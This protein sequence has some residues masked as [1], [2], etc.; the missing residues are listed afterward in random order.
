MA[1]KAKSAIRKKIEIIEWLVLVNII[2]FIF[3]AYQ[4]NIVN[5]RVTG[6]S[7]EPTF[8]NG[9]L[10]FGFTNFK[11]IRQ[12]D[13]VAYEVMSENK[14]QYQ[15]KRVI[16]IPNQTVKIDGSNVYV[17]NVLVVNNLQPADLKTEVLLGPDEYFVLADNYD[18]DNFDS[19]TA[20]PIKQN[21]IKSLILF[22][23]DNPNDQL[24]T[25]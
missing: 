8:E 19:R 2:I 20:G 25:K 23:K 22:S 14:I 10:I 6:N 9:D 18:A 5:A 21:D 3:T 15:I 13:V 1:K 4:I 24:V 7:M 11:N 16:A 12:N 17:N